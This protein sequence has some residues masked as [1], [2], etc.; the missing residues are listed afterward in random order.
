[1]GLTIAPR[2]VSHAEDA[3][4]LL[5]HPRCQRVL[6]GE[7]LRATVAVQ[8]LAQVGALRPRVLALTDVTLIDLH[9]TSLRPLHRVPLQHVSCD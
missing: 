3:V 7:T 2:Q 6:R 4:G 1:M 9:A 8:K 5:R